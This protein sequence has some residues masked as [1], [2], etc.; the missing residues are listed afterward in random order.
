MKKQN[1]Y[2]LIIFL[3]FITMVMACN[4]K[5]FDKR[6]WTAKTDANFRPNER[7]QMINDLLSNHKLVGLKYVDIITLLGAPDGID[8]SSVFYEIE[9]DYGSDIDPVYKKDLYLFT[10]ED[11]IIT[12]TRL[13]N[14]R[15]HTEGRT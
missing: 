12:H 9:I 1:I 2:S 15:E 3:V 10:T 4:E 13:K 7:G 6:R 5:K 11:S 14:G 8:S